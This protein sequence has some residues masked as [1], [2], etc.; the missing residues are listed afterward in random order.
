MVATL[1]LVQLIHNNITH[2][3]D[4]VPWVSIKLYIAITLH[5][6]CIQGQRY[7]ESITCFLSILI[8]ILLIIMYLYDAWPV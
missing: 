7:Y 3:L 6:L 5:N 4:V 8:Y 2:I 1:R